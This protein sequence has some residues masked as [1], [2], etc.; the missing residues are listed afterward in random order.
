MRHWSRYDQRSRLS[1]TTMF[2]FLTLRVVAVVILFKCLKLIRGS[3][4]G[5]DVGELR[6][7]Y[8]QHKC[9]QLQLHLKQKYG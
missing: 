7:H 6:L 8:V 2:V 1:P 5:C 3:P 4:Q 9:Q